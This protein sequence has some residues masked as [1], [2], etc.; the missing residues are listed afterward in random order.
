M[1]P[2]KINKLKLKKFR[3]ATDET[4]F[5]FDPAKRLVVIFGENGTGKTTILDAIDFAC[6]QNNEVSLKNKSIGAQKYRYLSSISSSLADLAVEIETVENKK[7]VAR[8]GSKGEV[9]VDSGLLRVE[10]LRRDSILKIVNGQPK[11]RFEEIRGMVSYPKVKQMED[12][13]RESQKNIT[14][15]YE[16]AVKAYEQEEANLKGFWDEVGDKTKNFLV[17]AKD[18]SALIKDDLEKQ[19]ILWENIWRKAEKIQTVNESITA[20]EKKISELSEALVTKTNDF[21]EKIRNESE[22]EGLV[23][24]LERAKEYIEKQDSISSC[25]VCKNDIKRDSLISDIGVRVS[26]MNDLKQVQDEIKSITLEKKNWEDQLKKNK[27]DFETILV[28]I[29]SCFNLV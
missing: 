23:D 12:A 16:D 15:S 17:W 21:Q 19:R 1:M 20:Q 6:N 8:F 2:N 26:Q 13:L 24:L 4:I 3:G 7:C 10:I 25:P 9:S 29:Q 18:R 22:K 5:E 14:K 11:E 28:E 27:S